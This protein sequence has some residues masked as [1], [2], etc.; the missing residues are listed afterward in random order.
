MVL[1]RRYLASAPTSAVATTI[2]N[3]A[4]TTGTVVEKLEARRLVHSQRE[5]GKSDPKMSKTGKK[6]PSWERKRVSKICPASSDASGTGARAAIDESCN[7]HMVGGG[8]RGQ[9]QGGFDG[10]RAGG[11]WTVLTTTVVLAFLVTGFRSVEAGS[12]AFV[13]VRRL[14]LFASCVMSRPC[15]F[16]ASSG[17]GSRSATP[18]ICSIDSSATLTL[19]V[20]WLTLCQVYL[21]FLRLAVDCTWIDTHVLR[22]HTDHSCSA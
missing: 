20:P 2:T 14:L 21:Q 12:C 4:A 9:V 19:Y 15:V 3:R 8:G 7:G 18:C 16:L 10:R 6:G 11:I 1:S 17:Q 5:S 13:Q 22:L